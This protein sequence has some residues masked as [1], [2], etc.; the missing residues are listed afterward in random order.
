MRVL[1]FLQI[2]TREA[3]PRHT[4]TYLPRSISLV[5]FLMIAPLDDDDDAAALRSC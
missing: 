4:A 1:P 2:A 5:G 3:P